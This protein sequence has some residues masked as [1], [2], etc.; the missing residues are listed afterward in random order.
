QAGQKLS[1]HIRAE[2]KAADLERKIQHIEKFGPILVHHLA[3]IVGAPKARETRAEE[4]LKKLLGRD[5]N[6]AEKGWAEDEG[7]L[8]Q[9]KAKQGGRGDNG[10]G[11][12]AEG[13][14][15]AVESVE[16]TT[17]IEEEKPKKSPPSSKK[18]RSTGKVAV[19]DLSAIDEEL[20]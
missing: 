11:E 16:S 3:E 14:P 19:G 18:K 20:L 9:L 6:S 8:Q 4:G 7:S 12:G 10:G 15:E 13:V 1:R 17:P 2:H 5:A